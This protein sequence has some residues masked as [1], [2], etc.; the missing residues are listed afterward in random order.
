MKKNEHNE[1]LIKNRL[2]R[3][4]RTLFE[5]E[6]DHYRPERVNNFWNNRY[7]EYETNGDK[8]RNLSLN[9]YLNN[10][11]PSF[12]NILTDLQNSDEWKIQLTIAINFISSKD[13]E[14]ERVM[15]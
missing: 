8:I 6:E 2:I 12:R 14:E 7:I 1:K 15:H 5:Q 13:A 3:D 10:I 11:E 4:I 9:E